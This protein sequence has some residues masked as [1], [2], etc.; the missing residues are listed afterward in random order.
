MGKESIKRYK[1]ASGVEKWK[2]NEYWGVNPDTGKEV[3]ARKQGFL[4][5]RDAI[6]W[7][8]EEIKRL[9]S[10]L[11]SSGH[12]VISFYNLIQEWFNIYAMSGVS[13]A[14][15]NST[16]IL[17][18]KYVP[19]DVGTKHAHRITT[20]DVQKCVELMA[21]SRKDYTRIRNILRK[22]LNRA[23]SEGIL[24]TNPADN[25]DY[26]GLNQTPSSE[27][28]INFY[29]AD[30]MELVLG[31][32]KE[33]LPPLRW[34]FFSALYYLGLRKGEALA[35]HTNDINPKDDT[36]TIDKTVTSDSDGKSIISEYTKTGRANPY[37]LKDLPIPPKFRD[38]LYEYTYK[39][40]HDESISPDNPFIFVS[41]LSK[42]KHMSSNNPNYWL[43]DFYNKHSEKLM[44]VGI[45]HGITPHGFRHSCASALFELGVNIKHVQTF[46]R[47]TNSKTT[48][49]TY[50][51]VTRQSLTVTLDDM[52]D[53]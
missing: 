44:D 23:I 30:E 12:R 51:H 16:R 19:K 7:R 2:V 41:P 34:V 33:H 35:L 48:L 10:T 32:M 1:T 39:R 14:T 36:V 29:T 49:D 4:Y 38:T 3:T 42:N 28:F 26:T 53:I 6:A 46:L 43:D 20:R 47:H 8:D 5:K 45:Y 18:R 24:T 21:Q 52:W 27:N 11:G 22:V 40:Y 50:T 13:P 25:V 37:L 15:I 9:D 31:I 17:L